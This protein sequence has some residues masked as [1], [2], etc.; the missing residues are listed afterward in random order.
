MSDQMFYDIYYKSS[1][2]SYE[3]FQEYM[4]QFHYGDMLPVKLDSGKE[5]FY[6]P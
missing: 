6:L 3:Q 4:N 2:L 5:T 1:E